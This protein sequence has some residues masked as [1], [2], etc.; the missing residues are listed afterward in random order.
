MNGCGT[1]Y[2]ITPSG[3]ETVLYSFG[4]R[5]SDGVRPS[6]AL[7]QASDGDLYGTTSAGGPSDSVLSSGWTGV[8]IE[9][10]LDLSTPHDTDG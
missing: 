10:R 3:T 1:L 9:C 8:Q 5:A 7:L 2:R 4:T 6:G